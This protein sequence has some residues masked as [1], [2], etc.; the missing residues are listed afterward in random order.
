ME[1]QY[2]PPLHLPLYSSMG[3]LF[4]RNSFLGSISPSQGLDF[5]LIIL[6]YRLNP[7]HFMQPAGR[8]LSSRGCDYSDLSS[9]IATRR[10]VPLLHRPSP[11]AL[12]TLTCHQTLQVTVDSRQTLFDMFAFSLK[13]CSTIILTCLFCSLLVQ[14]AFI[15]SVLDEL[16]L[17]RNCIL[18]LYLL[19][20]DQH[21]AVY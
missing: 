16:S 1:S 13:A 2:H 19:K 6:P 3:M 9:L 15:S 7:H 21:E 20:E 14:S 10:L 4:Q 5:S 8:S 12:R 11:Q 18:V 17:R